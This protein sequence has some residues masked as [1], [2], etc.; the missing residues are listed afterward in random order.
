MICLEDL[1]EKGL[2]L[3]IAGHHYRLIFNPDTKRTRLDYSAF[4][5][6]LPMPSPETQGDFEIAQKMIQRQLKLM[7]KSRFQAVADA[8]A[9]RKNLPSF[10]L[11]LTSARCRWGSCNSN[12]ELR[13]NWRLMYYP[14]KVIEYVVAHEMAHLI[15]MNHSPAFWS[16]VASLMPDF[17]PV[18]NYLSNMNP[19]KVPL[20]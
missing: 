7:A 17:Q 2:K 12:G 16:E 14:D 20:I 4:E 19:D 18:H 13:L 9:A 11:H 15:Q 3:P 10:S 5:L 1:I 8:V 6:S